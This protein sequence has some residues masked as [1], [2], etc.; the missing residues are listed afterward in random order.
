MSDDGART[1]PR[2][3]AD[4][5]HLFFSG[6]DD[7]GTDG[8]DE[9][10]SSKQAESGETLFL[11][12][13]GGGDA[14]GKSTVAVNMAHALLPLG[15]TAIFDA[16]SSLPNA[17][18]YLGMP[19]WNYL[20]PIT[21]DGTQV[22]NVETDA[23]L[24]IGDWSTGDDCIDRTLGGGSPVQIE[25]PDGARRLLRFAVVDVPVSRMETIERIRSRRGCVV[26]VAR[27]G[28]AGFVN[29]FAALR[30][31]CST[32]A[33]RAVGLVVNGVP[34]DAY[35]I[36]YYAKM[37]EAAERLLSVDVVPLGGV[38]SQPG[39]ASVQRERGVIVASRPGALAALSLRRIASDAVLLAG[40]H[41]RE[42]AFPMKVSGGKAEP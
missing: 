32:D 28:R 14:P 17:R 31:L 9:A 12:V 18:F 1:P 8:V 42:S 13:T 10:A 2:T 41:A 16:D 21:G 34:D 11:V 40:E 24:I 20:S 7:V 39:M 30:S 26:L 23:G 38:R 36:D 15:R 4:V 25:C 33:H 19:S 37:K 22:P 5:S 29:A 3:L 35:A 27:P 6:V